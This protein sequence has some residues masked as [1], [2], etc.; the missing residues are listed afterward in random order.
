MKVSM[1]LV[2]D[3][4]PERV[5]DRFSAHVLALATAGTTVEVRQIG[6]PARPVLFGSDHPAALA[7]ASAFEK[8]WG[9]KTV[10]VRTGGTIPV[11]EDFVREL[12]APMIATGFGQPGGGAHSPN[13][14]QELD[15]FHRGTEMLIHLFHDYA[16]QR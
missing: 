10:F 16:E 7:C 5:F 14:N 4:D 9:E 13:E 6:P 12:G 8:A 15:A 2:P 3:Q 11:A 1:R